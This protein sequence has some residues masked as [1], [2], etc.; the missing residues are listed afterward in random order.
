MIAL[1]TF[2]IMIALGVL[3]EPAVLL[4][5]G[6]QWRASIP[7]PQLLCVAGIALATNNTAA[8]LFLSQ[9][10]TDVLFRLGLYATAVRAIGVV[11]GAHWELMGV[12]WA[13]VI[14]GYVF[15]WYPT[16]SSAGRLVNL[17]FAALLRNVAGPFACAAAMGV[18]LWISD[19]WLFG[20]WLVAWRLA[21]QMA[22]GALVYAVLVRWFRLQAWVEAAGILIE[23]S[24]KRSRLLRWLLAAKPDIHAS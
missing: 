7:I 3:A 13:Y 8:W 20:G 18:L 19:R 11:I 5:Y 24:G 12:A 14:G 10:R 2:P 4:V 1:L 23:I 16:W 15:L 6:S 17:T 9:G 22:L 21:I